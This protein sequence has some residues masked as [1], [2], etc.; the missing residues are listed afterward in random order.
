MELNSIPSPGNPYDEP[1][2]FTLEDSENGK[3][4]RLELRYV[5]YERQLQG[6]SSPPPQ[7]RSRAGIETAVV[8]TK[9]MGYGTSAIAQQIADVMKV[10]MQEREVEEFAAF[11]HWMET[12]GYAMGAKEILFRVAT[13]SSIARRTREVRM[14]CARGLFSTV[15]DAGLRLSN[16]KNTQILH[17]PRLFHRE[18]VSIIGRYDA[19]TL[20]TRV[21]P[22]HP[23]RSR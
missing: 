12:D 6:V 16:M 7:A 11:H 20:V 22:F 19:R 15:I 5:Y 18:I 2:H 4:G 9:V 1:P 13:N 17:D 3:R 21:P 14:L 8:L 10:L 23:V